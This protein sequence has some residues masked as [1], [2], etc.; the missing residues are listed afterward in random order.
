MTGLALTYNIMDIVHLK[1]KSATQFYQ[2]EAIRAELAEQKS[3]LS[4]QL[5]Q[6]D[7][8]IQASLDKLKE[9]P[10]QL[11][12]SQDA[13][14]QKLAQ[15][16][17]GLINIVELTDVSYLLY[18]AETDEVEARSELLNTLLQKAVTNNTLNSFL[19]HF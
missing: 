13:Y 12:A 2:S 6:A 19:S 18:R 15:Y 16:N 14:A 3:L 4:T 17:S 10:V 1:D 5:N 9:I 8:A 7:I 11:K